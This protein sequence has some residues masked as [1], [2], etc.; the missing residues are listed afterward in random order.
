[1]PEA[2]L[3]PAQAICPHEPESCA[4]ANSATPAESS[5]VYISAEFVSRSSIRWVTRT[6]MLIKPS[7]SQAKIARNANS[8]DLIHD[9]SIAFVHYK[10][11]C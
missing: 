11:F 1:M 5:I 6:E 4:S 3:E 2:G 8:E 7:T 10:Y 9:S